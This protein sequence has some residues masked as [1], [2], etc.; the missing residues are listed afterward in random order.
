[1]DVGLGDVGDPHAVALGQR[2]DPVDVPL[3]VDHDRHAAI[4]RQVAAVP[5]RRRLDRHDLDHGW[6]PL[7]A[8]GNPMR[9]MYADLPGE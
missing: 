7:S 4:V 1:V 2:G 3:R 9:Q 5:E 6:T 8:D